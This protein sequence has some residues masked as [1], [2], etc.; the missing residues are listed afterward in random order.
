MCGRFAQ[1]S[2]LDIIRSKFSVD[3]IAD[4]C[5]PSYNIA[6]LQDIAAVAEHNGRRLG[7]MRW[8]LIPSWSRD[9]SQASKRINARSETVFDK[10]GFRQAVLQ[11]RCLIIADGFYEWQKT[12]TGKQPWFIRLP[13]DEPFAFAALYDIWHGSENNKVTTCSIITGA[14]SS[15]IKHI[16]PRMPLVLKPEAY[17]DWLS[18]CVHGRH[19]IAD[20]LINGTMQTFDCYRVTAFV[21]KAENNSPRCI[22]QIKKS[23]T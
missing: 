9:A 16:H 8:G 10:P 20:I 21:N 1:Y 5:D 19:P 7:K 2:S 6:P 11:R 13:D 3:S 22:E 17:S 18:R 14:A 23:G 12:D 15:D 4:F